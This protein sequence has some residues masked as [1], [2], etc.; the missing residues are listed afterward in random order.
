M[1]YSKLFGKTLRDLPHGMRSVSQML[2]VQGGFIRLLGHG[3]YSLLPLGNRVL[4]NIQG[5]VR[6]EMEGLGGLEV[7]VPLVNPYEIW[8]QGGRVDL[9]NKGIIRFSDRG[10]REYV[11]SPSH[12]EAMVELVNQSLKSYR[13]F[14]LFLFQFQLKF[15]DEEKIKA[16]LIRSKEFMMKDGYSFH[17]TYHDLNNFFPKVF[18]AYRR[19]FQRCGVECVSAESA[20]GY[21]AGEKAYEFLLPL[22]SGDDRIVVCDH[23]G[24]RA[25][26]DIAKG[27]K[28]AEPG[29]ERT[30]QTVDTP[31]ATTMDELSQYLET[32]TSTLAKSMVY[33]VDDGYIMAVVRGDYEGSEQKISAVLGRP[34]QRLATNEELSGL[35]LK[36]GYLS[37][38]GREDLIVVVDDCVSRSSN[39]I[40][41]ANEYGKHL[42]NVNYERDY[43]G[44]FVGDISR[45]KAENR[46]LQC[47]SAL[48]EFR[49]ME[50]GNVFKL[51]DFYTRSMGLLFQDE[52]GDQ[53]Y[54]QMGSYGI[55]LG[56]LMSAVV[57]SHH[58]DRGIAWP[59]SLA[60]FKGFL[61]GIGKSLAVKRVVYNLYEALKDQVLLDDR[62]E[63]PGVKFNDA[64]LI[65]IPFRIVVTTRLLESGKVEFRERNSDKTW[66]ISIEKAIEVLSG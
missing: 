17:R 35:G 49:A 36:P 32:P 9:I 27:I 10:G 65:G 19:I 39:L 47:H 41:G 51:R 13:D 45:I 66:N 18:A 14:P 37:P 38:V 54:P 34:L 62:L 4:R 24:Y 2:L 1:K 33:R 63:S 42:M 50:L 40:F 31:N 22:E 29:E 21:M 23:C 61:M 26:T 8:R 30:V 7:R 52:N 53:T 5:I 55:G 25:N 64:D 59:E 48:R 56:R 11:L 44:N 28:S 12:E 3:L 15:R 58:D 57:E 43:R 6:E 16:G 60:P 20:V 46:C